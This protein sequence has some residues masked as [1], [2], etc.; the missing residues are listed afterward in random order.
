MSETLG[1]LQSEIRQF[2]F[3]EISD[4]HVFVETKAAYGKDMVTGFIKLNGTTVGAV[5]NR[6]EIYDEDG[7][8]GRDN[9]TQISVPARGARKRCKIRSVL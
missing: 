9:G 3:L 6:T 4:N 5:A 1:E 7:N 2:C 8:A